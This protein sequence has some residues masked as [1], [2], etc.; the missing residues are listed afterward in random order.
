MSYTQ[1]STGNITD[2]LRNAVPEFGQAGGTLIHV[3]NT[4]DTTGP[5]LTF[6]S[7]SPP[8]GATAS[9]GDQIIITVTATDNRG[10]TGLVL[11]PGTTINGMPVDPVN[12]FEEIGNNGT[13]QFRVTVLE[14]P[15]SDVS[16]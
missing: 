4:L 5:V 1:Q 9:I 6:K 11:A 8:D 7:V 10:T 15:N 13:Y 12:G 16:R 14:A 3:T 2:T